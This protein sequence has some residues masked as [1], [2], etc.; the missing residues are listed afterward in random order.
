MVPSVVARGGRPD[1]RIVVEDVAGGL[2]PVRVPRLLPQR[3]GHVERIGVLGGLGPGIRDVPC[4][5]QVLRVLHGHDRRHAHTRGGGLQQL[6]GV[7]AHW[8]P[9]GLLLRPHLLHNH[10]ARLPAGAL[11][12][13]GLLWVEGPPLP[14]LELAGPHPRHV[15]REL[16]SPERL[17]L[18]V[19][20]LVVTLHT[21]PERRGLA[22]TVRDDLQVA[23]KFL[24]AV[25]NQAARQEPGERYPDLQVQLLT[26]I[27][28]HRHVL[29]GSN[30]RVQRPLHLWLSQCGELCP[31]DVLVRREVL[32]T[33]AYH[34]KADVLPL[35]VAV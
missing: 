33:D 32:P 35:A 34:L 19:L 18:K 30:E 13:L 8:S 4:R 2:A 20:D 28:G 27:D 9:H 10:L 11:H 23:V 7:Q 24:P 1:H 6:H 31:V 21:E 29:V 15:H 17:A 16:R 26:C 12:V 14:P 3:L 25:F 22:R 5:V